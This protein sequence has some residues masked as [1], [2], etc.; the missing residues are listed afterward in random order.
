MKGRPKA[1]HCNCVLKGLLKQ[2]IEER[3]DVVGDAVV[4]LNN[5]ET[6]DTA[7]RLADHLPEYITRDF[8]FRNLFFY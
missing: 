3:V 5:N 7:G 1:T 6:S 2:A 8:A 4:G